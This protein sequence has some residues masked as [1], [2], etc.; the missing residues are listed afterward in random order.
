MVV[1]VL[2]LICKLFIFQWVVLGLLISIG[3]PN[4]MAMQYPFANKKRTTYFF[5]TGLIAL[6]SYIV[7]GIN[8]T[9]TVWGL[10]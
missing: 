3:S 2:T 4:L 9:L 5:I 10:I 6:F 1:T 8:Y 7:L